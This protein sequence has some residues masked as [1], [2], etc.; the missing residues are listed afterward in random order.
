MVN[1]EEELIGVKPFNEKYKGVYRALQG[2]NG[3][4]HNEEAILVVDTEVSPNYKLFIYDEV[5][6]GETPLKEVLT[7]KSNCL[8]LT[9]HTDNLDFYNKLVEAINQIQ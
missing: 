5:K 3:Y 8:I 4:K 1:I 2:V 7:G 6:R 9:V